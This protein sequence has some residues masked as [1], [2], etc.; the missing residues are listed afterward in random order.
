MVGSRMFQKSIDHGLHIEVE[1]AVRERRAHIVADRA[2]EAG[3][4][5]GR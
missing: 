2:V 4:A 1:H 5:G 3:I